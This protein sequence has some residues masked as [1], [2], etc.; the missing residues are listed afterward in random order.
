M[1]ISNEDRKQLRRLGHNLNPVV[2]IAGNGL[3]KN[4]LA[5]IDRALNDHEL[6]KV[7]ICGGDSKVKSEVIKEI[8]E[9]LSAQTVQSVGHIALLLK[10]SE[11]PNPRLSNLLR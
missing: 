6:I 9:R 7:K 3:S 8:C 2:T 10:K 11:K 4:V 1:K 5:E